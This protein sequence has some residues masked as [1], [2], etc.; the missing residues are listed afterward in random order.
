[1]DVRLHTNSSD[2][3]ALPDNER[4]SCWKLY[5]VQEY[6]ELVRH[7]VG[8]LDG[9]AGKRRGPGSAEDGG[10]FSLSSTIRVRHL[11]IILLGMQQYPPGAGPRAHSPGAPRPSSAMFWSSA[12]EG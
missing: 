4:M 6:C 3:A 7:I 8:L 9:E 2:G 10:A 12:P 5:I 1:M 11:V